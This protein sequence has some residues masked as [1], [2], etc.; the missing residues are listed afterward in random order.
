MSFTTDMLYT[1]IKNISGGILLV[2]F[3]GVGGAKLA[4]GAEYSQLG[5]L[6]DW[7]LISKTGLNHKI[8][9]KNIESMVTNQK[10]A[11]LK[12]PAVVVR[13][14]TVTANAYR[15]DVANAIARI[16]PVQTGAA[17]TPVVINS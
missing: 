5:T 14:A 15:F 4:D 3:I 6:V 2:P 7:A 8:R 11:V 1:T 17:G 12:T 13:D 9:L 10:I 16:I